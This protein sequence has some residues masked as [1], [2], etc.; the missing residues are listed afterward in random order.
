[1]LVV[2]SDRLAAA[3]RGLDP[4]SRA[5]LDLSLRQGVPDREIA[6]LLGS[7]PGEVERRRTEVLERIAAEAGVDGDDA[8]LRETLASE[9]SIELAPWLHTANG[10]AASPPG[11]DLGRRLALAAIP[12]LVAGALIGVLIGVD[13]GP[14][15]GRDRPA[16]P[17]GPDR[18]SQ[19]GGAGAGNRGGAPAPSGR[20][21]VRLRRLAGAPSSASGEARLEGRGRRARV[22]ISVYGLPQPAG[23]YQA[24]LYNS[25]ADAVRLGEVGDGRT[26]LRLPRDADPGEFDFIDVS[27]EPADGNAN[28]S[29]QSLL[30]VPI[31]ALERR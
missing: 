26:T 15:R 16:S 8:N 29:G 22:E 12:I 31:S 19:P 17:G 4:A 2:P 1:M 13:D 18:S 21:R 6:E 10:G 30:R 23:T 27:L 25:I 24:W 20:G 9:T 7:D 11:P 5:L 3:V 28:H 14:E